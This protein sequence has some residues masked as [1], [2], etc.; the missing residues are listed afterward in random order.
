MEG[1]TM[2]PT[3]QTPAEYA[4][5]PAPQPSRLQRA[6]SF[7]AF[8]R[9][10]LQSGWLAC[11]LLMLCSLAAWAGY[12]IGRNPANMASA[13]GHWP[14][15]LQPLMASATHGGENLAIATG[16]IDEDVEGIF[17][18]DFLTGDLQCWVYYPRQGT[19]GGQFVGNVQAQLPPVGKN[20]KYLMVTGLASPGPSSGIQRASGSLVYVVDIQA[21]NFAA[22]T[23]PWVRQSGRSGQPQAGQLFPVGGGKIRNQLGGGGN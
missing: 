5:S 17:F 23:I 10:L 12:T 19:F 15:E 16:Q 2:P 22:Y 7:G 13:A 9:P 18:L 6:G 11:W 8:F 21:G 1:E 4:P 14:A 3:N 20:P